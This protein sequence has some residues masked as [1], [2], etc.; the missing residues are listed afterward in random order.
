MLDP[1]RTEKDS[2]NCEA[3]AQALP[4]K[5]SQRTSDPGGICPENASEY[6]EAAPAM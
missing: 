1:F 6:L 3:T 2:P 4:E 5:I